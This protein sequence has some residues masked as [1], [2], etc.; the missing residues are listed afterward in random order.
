VQQG[1]DAAAPLVRCVAEKSSPAGAAP[2]LVLKGLQARQ[3][4]KHFKA[5]KAF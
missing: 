2:S 3:E 1:R 5:A 4:F